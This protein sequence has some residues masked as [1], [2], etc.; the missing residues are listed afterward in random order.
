M[1]WLGGGDVLVVGEDG[2]G[3]ADLRLSRPALTVRTDGAD[4]DPHPKATSGPTLRGP[5]AWALMRTM[6]EVRPPY[7]A[8]ELADFLGSTRATSPRCSSRWQQTG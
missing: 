4:R 1:S 3:N 2:T 5:R 6:V 7:T 8:G